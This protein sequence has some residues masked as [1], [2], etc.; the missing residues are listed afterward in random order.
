MMTK[1]RL[2]KGDAALVFRKDGIAEAFFPR[3]YPKT[4]EE[5][6]NVMFAQSL[7]WAYNN[8]EMMT[9]IVEAIRAEPSHRMN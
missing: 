9:A 4:M 8:D 5:A 1:I 2:G 7:F 3:P 6:Q